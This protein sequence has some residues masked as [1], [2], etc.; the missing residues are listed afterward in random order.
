MD[1]PSGSSYGAHIVWPRKS[2]IPWQAITPLPT[3]EFDVSSYMVKN[4]ELLFLSLLWGDFQMRGIFK[5]QFCLF[6]TRSISTADMGE[7]SL[8]LSCIPRAGWLSHALVL[9]WTF[10]AFPSWL[11]DSPKPLASNPK[12]LGKD[13]FSALQSNSLFFLSLLSLPVSCLLQLALRATYF[14]CLVSSMTRVCIKT[15]T[16]WAWWREF[17]EN[18]YIYTNGWVPLQSTWNDHNINIVNQLF[19]TKEKV[20]LKNPNDKTVLVPQTE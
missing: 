14:W 16:A 5:S 18:G 17:R 20:I 7:G 6:T 8:G 13:A 19:N 2:K 1:L 10:Q 9:L 11:P 12:H 4:L 15:A 3:F